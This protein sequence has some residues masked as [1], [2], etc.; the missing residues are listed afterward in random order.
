MKKLESLD[1][2]YINDFNSYYSSVYN[3]TDINNPQ[4]RICKL[5]QKEKLQVNFVFSFTND[6]ER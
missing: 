6:R 3:C 4:T 1:I 5:Y 2:D